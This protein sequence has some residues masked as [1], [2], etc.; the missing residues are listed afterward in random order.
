MRSQPG[1]REV[2]DLE[3]RLQQVDRFLVVAAEDVDPD[4][5]VLIEGAVALVL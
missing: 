2:R 4:E 1:V 3:Q 5:I